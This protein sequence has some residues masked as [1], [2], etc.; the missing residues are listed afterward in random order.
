MNQAK[1]SRKQ[2]H[3]RAPDS[4]AFVEAMRRVFGKDQVKVLYVE[5][6]GFKLGENEWKPK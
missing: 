4:A 2:N 6:N 1:T 5:E 3:D